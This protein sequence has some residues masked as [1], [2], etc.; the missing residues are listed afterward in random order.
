MRDLRIKSPKWTINLLRFK[1]SKEKSVAS[2][3]RP[4]QSGRLR[5]GQRA[6]LARR[7]QPALGATT[8]V[9]EPSGY[10]RAG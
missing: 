7:L 5:A 8:E 2:G 4:V 10:V 3:S 1:H 9:P 6:P